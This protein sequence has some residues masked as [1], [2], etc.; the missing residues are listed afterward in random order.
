V[1]EQLK[2]ESLESHKF[3]SKKKLETEK[4]IAAVGKY[5]LRDALFNEV[6]LFA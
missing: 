5:W 3:G 1:I 2:N 6:D 4:A